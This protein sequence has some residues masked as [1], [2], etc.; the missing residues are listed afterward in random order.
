MKRVT[1]RSIY[2]YWINAR[3]FAAFLKQVLSRP[4]NLWKNKQ[5]EPKTIK[6]RCPKLVRNERKRKGILNKPIYVYFHIRK[7]Q[8][9]TQK[10]LQYVYNILISNEILGIKFFKQKRS[11]N[12]QMISPF[13]ILCWWFVFVIV[14]FLLH[15]FAA[16]PTKS[17]TFCG[18]AICV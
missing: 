15:I 12:L 16:F 18:Q 8:S 6:K 7:H 11:F 5:G 4:T 17:T 2:H 9:P 3:G 10:A 14:C 1:S 13:C